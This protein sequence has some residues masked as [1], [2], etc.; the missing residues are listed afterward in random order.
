L[1]FS[2]TYQSNIPARKACV[3][4]PLIEKWAR[5]KPNDL[6]FI[7]DCGS[8]W[9][10]SEVLTLTRYTAS[11]F[12]NMG[13]E[14]GDHV[15]SW[16]PN[17][18][19]AVLTWFGLN[20]IGAV[21]V[22]M[23]TAYRGNLLQ[24]LIQLSDAKLLVCNARLAHRLNAIDLGPT[25]NSV[26]ITG[27]DFSVNNVTCY[28]ASHLFGFANEVDID[29]DLIERGEP[30]DPTYII[31]T[32]G[33]TGP[34]KA[35][36][37]SYVQLYA[38]G[39]EAHN[40]I[41]QFDR[42]L[43]NLPLFHVGGT[44]LVA[45]TVTFGC[46]CVVVDGFSSDRFWPVIR[47]HDITTAC[48]LGAMTP[49]L[50]KQPPSKKDKEHTLRHVI[51]VPWNENAA[52]LASRHGLKMRTAFNMTEICT[53]L[54]SDFNPKILGSCGK[55]RQG[56]EVR[57]VDEFDQTLPPGEIG[58][59]I[60]RTD[61]P[62]S[63]NSGYYKN[64]G[65]TALAWRNGWFHTGDAF[66]YDEDNNF[67]FIDRIKDAIRRRGENISSFEI[68]SEVSAHPDV[69]DVA[70]VAV[71]SEFSEDEVLIVVSEVHGRQVRPEQLFRF[72]E[73]RMAH[74][75]LPSFIRI[76][77]ELPKTPTEKIRK[78]ILREEGVTE[79]TWFR[80][81]HGIIVKRQILTD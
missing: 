71:P 16:Q 49:F 64:P 38:T 70:A 1:K 11:R 15:L 44:V 77:V 35:V 53:P 52:A 30:W 78:D 20:Y 40:Y 69:A 72:L 59:L 63:M 50:L 61:R 21:F 68:E 17:N 58:E 2:S 66:R 22:P 55:P 37:S 46:S 23:N 45:I 65:A 76:M 39:A 8:Q 12:K 31:F 80:G 7:F 18:K 10:W 56:I 54:I 13:V 75:M 47:R 36:L 60:V 14:A 51:T 42:I 4:G 73:E 43:V 19:E 5:K 3:L 32:S 79:D 28:S 62:W 81:D 9:N 6:A 48:L 67:F 57:V 29:D 74:F 34:S 27:G 41:D 33:T 25:L 26:V 24:N